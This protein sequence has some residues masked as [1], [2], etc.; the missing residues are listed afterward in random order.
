[1]LIQEDQFCTDSTLSNKTST[2]AVSK[3]K[4]MHF[5]NWFVQYPYPWAQQSLLCWL[6]N[7]GT[8]GSVSRWLLKASSDRAFYWM[9]LL[10]LTLHFHRPA[11][12]VNELIYGLQYLGAYTLHQLAAGITA[13]LNTNH[14]PFKVCI[15]FPLMEHSHTK[16][17]NVG[18]KITRGADL[19]TAAVGQVHPAGRAEQ[20]ML[21][22]TLTLWQAGGL[23]DLQPVHG[24]QVPTGVQCDDPQP[25]LNVAVL[26]RHPGALDADVCGTMTQSGPAC[27]G[28]RRRNLIFHDIKLVGHFEEWV[29]DMFYVWEWAAWVLCEVSHPLAGAAGWWLCS[30]SRCPGWPGG[31]APPGTSAPFQSQS[32]PMA[33]SREWKVKKMEST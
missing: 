26:G 2:S 14:R 5:S 30:A 16:R 8:S 33:C 1:M 29:C 28:G 21:G 10:V 27:G 15:C 4:S 25:V 20:W 23:G 31:G 19:N 32:G 3:W 9:D 18:I 6:I 17:A 13:E 24:A 7:T 12:K 22:A 11:L